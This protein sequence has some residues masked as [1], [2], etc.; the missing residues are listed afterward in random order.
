[1]GARSISNVNGGDNSLWGYLTYS[2]YQ[3]G[4]CAVVVLPP[5]GGMTSLK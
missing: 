2:L 3:G 1:M 4:V 5:M